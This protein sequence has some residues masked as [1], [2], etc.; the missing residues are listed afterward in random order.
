MLRARIDRA[1]LVRLRRL[2][3]DHPG[4]YWLTVLAVGGLGA[5]DVAARAA[6]VDRQRTAWEL[7]APV[8]VARTEIGAGTVID[9]TNTELVALP[10]AAVP[11]ASFE[12]LVPD[13]VAV[14]PLVPGEV[15][16]AHHT[17]AAP[18]DGGASAEG[19]LGRSTRWRLA[20]GTV[21]V[22]VPFGSSSV[23]VAVGDHVTVFGTPDEIGLDPA[24]QAVGMLSASAEVV[25]TDEDR[26]VLAVAESDAE[27]VARAAATG[28]TVLVLRRSP[29]AAIESGE[30]GA[31]G[32]GPTVVAE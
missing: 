11:P 29:L 6:A 10:H 24:A 15:I 3:V 12:A 8:V 22:A 27:Q 4:A 2:L 31:T 13:L 18:T 20:P 1:T 26:V 21:G 23:P 30:D 17:T 7:T 19:S 9:A 32:T 28:R 16:L 14:D 25:A 5:A